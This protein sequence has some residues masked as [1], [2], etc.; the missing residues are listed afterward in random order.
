MSSKLASRAASSQ[1]QNHPERDNPFLNDDGNEIDLRP[2]KLS[3]PVTKNN[4]YIDLNEVP[5]RE[6]DVAG[7]PS[8]WKRR[9]LW[10]RGICNGKW[11]DQTKKRN[12]DDWY[13]CRTIACQLALSKRSKE[14]LWQIFRPLDMRSFRKYESRSIADYTIRPSDQGA[15]LPTIRPVWK[16]TRKQY[17]VVFCLC[18]LLYN[19]N[20]SE[21]QPDYYPGKEGDSPD[22]FGVGLRFARNLVDDEL[23]DCH[24]LLQQF[25]DRLGF[26]DEDIR[27][28]MEKLRQ[29]CPRLG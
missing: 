25:A 1:S 11:A 12:Q 8:K 20:K 18:A 16:A 5:S 23:R 3:S 6:W 26:R 2:I 7:M 27:S 15:D 29:D 24:E 17:L 14:A 19:Q 4:S 21:R 9:E 13:M 10:N 22:K 28:C